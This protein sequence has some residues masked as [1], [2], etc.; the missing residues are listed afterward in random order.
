MLDNFY[1]KQERQK[2]KSVSLSKNTE[3]IYKRRYEIGKSSLVDY[4][5]VQQKTIILQQ[6]LLQIQ[7]LR[8]LNYISLSLALGG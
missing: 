4:L 6:E 1:I 7:Q 8:W 2:H 3:K 5:R